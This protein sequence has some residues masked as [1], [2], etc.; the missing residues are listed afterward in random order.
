VVQ[1]VH[2]GLQVQV[3]LVAPVVLMEAMVL[4]VHLVQHQ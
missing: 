4:V 2:Q 1:V 3:V